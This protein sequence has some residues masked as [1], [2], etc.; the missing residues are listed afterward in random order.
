MNPQPFIAHAHK[1][2]EKT[3]VSGWSRVYTVL[4]SIFLLSYILFFQPFSVRQAD[5]RF[6]EYSSMICESGSGPGGAGLF[7]LSGLMPPSS[8]FFSFCSVYHSLFS[9]AY[10]S[11]TSGHL[12]F[13]PIG[14]KF[15]PDFEIFVFNLVW[16]HSTNLINITLLHQIPLWN[17]FQHSCFYYCFL[18]N[19]GLCLS[20]CTFS[21]LLST[22]LCSTFSLLPTSLLYFRVCLPHLLLYFRSFVLSS[23]FLFSL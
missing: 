21:A 12:F 13:F 20:I 7:S 4:S 23:V 10:P 8:P 3:V 19:T 2:L 14:T 15:I 16:I 6:I 18:A 9:F 17:S 1:K 5:W 11:F 22:T